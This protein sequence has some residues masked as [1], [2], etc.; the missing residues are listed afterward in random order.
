LG[1]SDANVVHVLLLLIA[2]NDSSIG[3][4][5][6]IMAKYERPKVDSRMTKFG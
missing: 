5:H 3:N 4:T 6:R 2:V 1:P